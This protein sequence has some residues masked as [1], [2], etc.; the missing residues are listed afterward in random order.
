MKKTLI[1]LT[2][3]LSP[4]LSLAWPGSSKKV[5]ARFPQVPILV[6]SQDGQ[7]LANI[8]VEYDVVVTKTGSCSDKDVNEIYDAT[9]DCPTESASFKESGEIP[10]VITD[11]N[12]QA[13]IPAGSVEITGKEPRLSI[14][15]IGP[16]V[17]V[18]DL[19]CVFAMSVHGWTVRELPNNSHMPVLLSALVSGLTFVRTETF[20]ALKDKE[21]SLNI[22]KPIVSMEV[23][24]YGETGESMHK[25]QKL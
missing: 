11:A 18:R 20:V 8:R 6:L 15:P 16:N 25:C 12:G 10:F 14:T 2:M 21:G 13:L 4:V 23:N 5:E 1:L 22:A 24:D 3:T 19:S 7:A 17:F 9:K